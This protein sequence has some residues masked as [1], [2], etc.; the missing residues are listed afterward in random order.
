[1]NQPLEAGAGASLY[2]KV[3]RL[4]TQSMAQSKCR[5]RSVLG[6][7]HHRHFSVG[8]TL[9]DILGINPKWICL[10]KCNYIANILLCAQSI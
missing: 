4:P 9:D 1:M 7:L 10:A 3:K 8:H 6:G 5:A 2:K